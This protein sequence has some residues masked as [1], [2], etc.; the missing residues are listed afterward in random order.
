MAVVNNEVVLESELLELEATFRQKLAESGRADIPEAALR[1]EVL[2]RAILQHLQLQRAQEMGVKVS[3]ESVNQ[4]LRRVAKQNDLSLREFQEVLAQ[5]GYD[6]TEFRES[7]RDEMIVGQLRKREVD[8]KILVSNREVDNFIS[9]QAVQEG[10]ATTSYHIF[11]ILIAVAEDPTTEQLAAGQQKVDEVYRLLDEGGDFEK[12][13]ITHSSGEN[14]L[15][16]GEVGWRQEADLPGLFV[17]VVS[18]LAENEVSEPIRSGA[19]FHLLKVTEKR[20]DSAHL[21]KQTLVSHI[22]V[23]SDQGVSEAAAKSRLEKLQER[24]LNGDDFAEIARAHSDDP[25]SAIE[26]GSLGWT[27]PGVMVAEFEEVMNIMSIGETSDVFKSR[28]GWHLLKVFDRREE[29]MA[30]EFKRNQARQQI[31]QRKAAEE[32]ENWLRQMRDE[33]YVEYRNR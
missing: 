11:H 26:G 8:D 4:A 9:T 20:T 27:S 19:G 5:D 2:E 31:Y 32:L 21:V 14:A 23:K 10:T 3:D 1:K 28:F 29:N 30:E 7:I 12:L 25:G 15:N 33:A 16:G 6:F 17:D 18:S 22:L 24:I 13:A